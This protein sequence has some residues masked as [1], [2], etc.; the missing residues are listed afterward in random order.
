MRKGVEPRQLKLREQI[1]VGEKRTV[2][3]VDCGEESFLIGCTAQSV[4]LL[5]KLPARHEFTDHLAD[6]YEMTEV[7]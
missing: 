1:T 7:Q 6:H 2:A 4:S 3:I 5:A